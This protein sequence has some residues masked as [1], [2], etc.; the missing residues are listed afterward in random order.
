MGIKLIGSADERAGFSHGGKGGGHG[1]GVGGT[2]FVPGPGG[3]GT[4]YDS[5]V[6]S[7]GATS[8]WKFGETSGTNFA[9]SIGSNPM[10][11]HGAATLAQTGPN[12]TAKAISITGSAANYLTLPTGAYLEQPDAA[13]TFSC[14]LWFNSPVSPASVVLMG[15]GRIG[16]GN[17]WL[18][19][20]RPGIAAVRTAFGSQSGGG[21]NSIAATPA[22]NTWHFEAISCSAGNPAVYYDGTYASAGASGVNSLLGVDPVLLAKQSDDAGFYQGLFALVSF[23]DGRALTQAELNQLYAQGPIG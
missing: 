23:H 19:Y 5:L 7:L 11:L 1:H 20:Y 6:A 22:I 2:G 18:V 12:A 3:G 13:R 14:C 4:T 10:T 9:D 21:A 17:G 8:Y 15:N 16:A